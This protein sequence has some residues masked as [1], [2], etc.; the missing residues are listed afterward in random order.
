MTPE[1]FADRIIEIAV[2]GSVV[3]LDLGSFSTTAKDANNQPQLELRQRIIMPA[4]GFIQSFALMTKLMQDLEKRGL[5]R[6][7]DAIG[8]PVEAP[9]AATVTPQSPNFK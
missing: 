2:T 1:L 9:T 5:I 4:E 3:R 7:A 6:R 8:A